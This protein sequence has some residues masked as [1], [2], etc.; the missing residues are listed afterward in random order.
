[1][2]HHF[3]I[4]NVFE[5]AAVVSGIFYTV[6]NKED[7]YSRYFVYF[8]MFTVFI[9]ELIFGW[10]PGLIKKIDALSF[11]KDTIFTSNQW[12][13]N[14]NDLVSFSFYLSFFA[15]Q[16]KSDRN[17]K[18]AFVVI[19]LFLISAIINLLLTSV[20]FEGISSYIYIVGSL[21]LFLFISYYF[22]QLFLSE[23]LLIFYKTIPF[24][25]AI[26]CSLF[27]LCVT[28][29]FIYEKFYFESINVEYKKI[30]KLLLTLINVFTYSTYTIGF[31]VC[32]KK[33]KSY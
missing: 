8:L 21:L 30:H 26:G 13:Y 24:Y 16:I 18:N 23:N 27:Y 17:K 31:I 4:I 29:I 5:I 12:T 32:S 2:I 33:K 22:F 6:K 7:I 14:I 28:P 19:I 25:V 11:L 20:F 9:V 3:I 15:F 1:M 10:L